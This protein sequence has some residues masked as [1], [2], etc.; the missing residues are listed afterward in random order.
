MNWHFDFSG[1]V[2]LVTGAGQG[3]GEDPHTLRWSADFSP[4]LGNAQRR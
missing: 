4:Q 3:L 2:T 1:Q